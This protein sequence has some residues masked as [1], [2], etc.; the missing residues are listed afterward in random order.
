MVRWL[1]RFAGSVALVGGMLA[2]PAVLS[3]TTPASAD[4][5]VDGCTIVSNPTSTH[6]T[7]CPNANLTG[8][9]LAGVNLSFA[10]LAGASL[11][12]C[13]SVSSCG[14]PNTD[15]AGANLTDATLTNVIMVACGFPIGIDECVRATLTGATLTGA[16]LTGATGAVCIVGSDGHGFCGAPDLSGANLSG[17][18]FSGA[19]LGTGFTDPFGNPVF[20]GA[21]LTNATLTGATFTSAS[22]SGVT[23]DGTILIPSNQTVFATSSAGAVATWPTP[24]SLPGAT[25]GTCS[26]PSG[27]TFPIG[28]DMVACGVVDYRGSNGLG[29]FTVTVNPPPSTSVL[30]PSDVATQSGTSALLDASA[31]AGVSGV[32]FEL[33]GGTLNNHVIATGT[34]TLYGWLAQW[35]TTSVAN[36]AYALQSVVTYPGGSVTSA[37]ITINVNN[38]PPSTSVLIPSDGASVSGTK[39][40]LDASASTSVTSV[41]FE[42]TGGPDNGT[43]ISAGAPTLYG[44]LGQ[45]NTTVVPNGTYTLQSVASY[46]GGVSGTSAPIT[47]TVNNPPP[48]TTVVLPSN[49]ASASGNQYLDATASP[50][51]TQ[52]TYEVSGGPANL[53]NDVIATGTPTPYG[54]LAAWNT[55]GVAN[56]TYTLQSVASYAGGVTG[57]SPPI[58]LTVAN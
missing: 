15:L 10:N 47:I 36:G 52:V 7:N 44:W 17:A 33:S 50:G 21:N 31:S 25:P 39:A 23:F 1:V 18:N 35:N 37:P 38:P 57:T 16:N 58:T 29:N 45:W 22:L 40:V 11:G 48:T 26:P 4:T 28:R 42:L 43:V 3:T 49:N 13:G 34:P 9:N 55:T 32:S 14:G 8:A 12:S 53:S 51:V 19:V 27:S 20:G 5:V 30:I 46:A 24:P 6:F 54:W 41:N 56:G 2:L